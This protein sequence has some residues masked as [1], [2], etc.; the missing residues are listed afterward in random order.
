M[1]TISIS[2]DKKKLSC[3]FSEKAYSVQQ[4]NYKPNAM[5]G[6]F[7]STLIQGCRQ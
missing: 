3:P 5:I 1:P 6:I 4:Q 7:I 2:E